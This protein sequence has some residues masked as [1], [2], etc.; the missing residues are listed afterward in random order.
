MLFRSQPC[1]QPFNNMY[2]DYNGSVM[3]CCNTRSDVPDN[4][5]AIMGSVYSNKLWDIYKSER[6]RYWREHLN[7]NEPKSGI[8]QKCK[9]DVNFEELI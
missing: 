7:N 9:I 1:K 4:E 3:V 2:I 5:N 8:C 6:Y